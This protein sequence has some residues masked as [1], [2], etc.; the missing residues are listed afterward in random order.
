MRKIGARNPVFLEKPGFSNLTNDLGMLFA[1]PTKKDSA[2]TWY[3]RS[4][5]VPQLRRRVFF[6][7]RRSRHLRCI[8]LDI[9]DSR[10]KISNNN[11]PTSVGFAYLA[12]VSTARLYIIIEAVPV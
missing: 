4:V 11:K 3:R 5:A 8:A 6:G 1:L 9:Q 7:D 2:L 12:V 10:Y